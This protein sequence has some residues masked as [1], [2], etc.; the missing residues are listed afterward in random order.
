MDLRVIR[1]AGT[2][3]EMGHQHGTQLGENIRSFCHDRLAAGETYLR[4]RG[5]SPA[6]FLD[7]ARASLE[8]FR[9]WDS[10]GFEEHTA[11]AAAA[12]VSSEILFAAGNFTDLRDVAALARPTP[13]AEGC[14]AVISTGIDG[15]VVCGQ[16]W[17]L[18]PSDVA[19][20]VAI[21][22]TP[23]DGSPATFGITVA[24]CP[25]IVG[26]NSLGLTWGTT[27]LKVNDVRV[28]GV[29]YLCVLG[30]VGR[31]TTRAEASNILVDAPRAAAHTF[32]LADSSGGEIWESS[33]SFTFV[34]RGEQLAQ[35]NHAQAQALAELEEERP[36]RTSTARLATAL[37]AVNEASSL[38]G[39][40]ALTRL[41]ALF[42]DR[43]DG[44]DSVSRWPED[45]TG[46][47]TNAVLVVEPCERRVHACR[48]P[49]DRGLWYTFEF[50]TDLPTSA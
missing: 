10:Q 21:H 27:N 7:A 15:V 11:I 12:G 41:R 2:S 35:T 36:S 47:T 13:D 34:R 4:L 30:R 23:S 49:A 20:V 46:T 6:R 8:T 45:S 32:W 1:L 14:T 25:A 44:V 26:M 5:Q 37:E 17:D 42:C 40:H 38:P 39:T 28:G 19:H 48:G 16:T 31:C 22:R 33:A 43:R 50:A 9:S 24:G 18:N 3:A 29:P